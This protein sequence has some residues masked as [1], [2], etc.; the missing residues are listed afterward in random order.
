MTK[1]TVM[2]FWC[3]FRHY[4]GGTIHDALREFSTLTEKER[5]TFCGIL[6][7]NMANISDIYHARDFM[8]E[9]MRL[10]GLVIR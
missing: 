10:V 1:K 9:R 7:D 2:D 3:G 8:N 6:V 5:D 4:Q